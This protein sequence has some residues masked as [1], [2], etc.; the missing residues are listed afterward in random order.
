LAEVRVSRLWAER[1][2]EAG[3]VNGVGLGVAGSACDIGV[4]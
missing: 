4:E 2:I 3:R 1:D